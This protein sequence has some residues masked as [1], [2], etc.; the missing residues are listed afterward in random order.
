[1]AE[2][3]TPMAVPSSSTIVKAS[4]A[5]ASPTRSGENDPVARQAMIRTTSCGPVW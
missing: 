1:M 2:N 4:R 5:A 3:I